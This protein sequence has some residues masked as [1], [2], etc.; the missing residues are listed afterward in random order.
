[1]SIASADSPQPQM[2][3]WLNTTTVQCFHTKPSLR[4][5]RKIHLLADIVYSTDIAEKIFFV[6]HITVFSL[7]TAVYTL[8]AA[9]EAQTINDIFVIN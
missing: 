6:D 7:L 9:I 1:M 5:I 4:C 8:I 2:I 3:G